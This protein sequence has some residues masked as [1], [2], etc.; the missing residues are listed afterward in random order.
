M[1][2]K[3]RGDDVLRLEREKSEVS[4]PGSDFSVK[5][6]NVFFRQLQ[7]LVAQANDGKAKVETE[8][9]N[10]EDMRDILA[11]DYEKLEDKC[12][13]LQEELEELKKRA[14]DGKAAHHEDVTKERARY[15]DLKAQQDSLKER[16]QTEDLVSILTSPCKRKLTRM[17]I[18]AL[19]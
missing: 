7:T 12:S 15:E 16:Y 1:Q 6:L 11:E 13:A 2:L 5:R 17:L 4:A 14:E 19:I 8:L 10:I 18:P 9:S 3:E